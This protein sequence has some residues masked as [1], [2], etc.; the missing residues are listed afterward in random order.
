MKET[1]WLSIIW[2]GK[3]AEINSKG[4]LRSMAQPRKSK[5]IQWCF[6]DDPSW[7]T[8]KCPKKTRTF[9]SNPVTFTITRRYTSWYDVRHAGK[10]FLMTTWHFLMRKS[11]EY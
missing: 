7:C 11:L 3:M 4:K 8:P 9:T 5:K 10:W 2:K 6:H 1:K